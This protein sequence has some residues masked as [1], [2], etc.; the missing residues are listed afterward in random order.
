MTR[1]RIEVRV[2][3]LGQLGFYDIGWPSTGFYSSRGC[4]LYREEGKGSGTAGSYVVSTITAIYC[5]HQSRGARGWKAVVYRIGSN[6]RCATLLRLVVWATPWSPLPNTQG[7]EKSRRWT[8]ALKEPASSIAAAVRPGLAV[9]SILWLSN[10]PPL[11]PPKGLIYPLYFFL[12]NVFFFKICL[13][14]HG[15]PL[16]RSTVF[17]I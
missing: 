4:C 5:L 16:N 9:G 7:R 15:F 6:T 13:L 3:D 12:E 10:S 8:S 1:G 11:S 14:L 17:R 2:A